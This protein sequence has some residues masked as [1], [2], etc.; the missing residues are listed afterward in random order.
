MNDARAAPTGLAPWHLWCVGL[1]M[2]VWNAMSC[3]SHVMTL[4]RNA[5]GVFFN[6]KGDSA[7]LAAWY[8]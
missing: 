1:L 6:S 4:T 3:F 2:L 7:A 8:R 5:G